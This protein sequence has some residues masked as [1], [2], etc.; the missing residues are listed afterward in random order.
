MSADTVNSFKDYAYAAHDQAEFLHRAMDELKSMNES[1]FVVKKNKELM[2]E[3]KELIEQL[4][5]AKSS[6]F[7][8]QT[9][10]FNANA[11]NGSLEEIRHQLEIERNRSQKA[12][13][14]NQRVENDKERLNQQ[15]NQ[16]LESY[17]QL[18]TSHNELMN[19]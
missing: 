9:A 14:K 16:M 3:K 6:G 2:R 18:E 8:E 17:R 11:G 7:Q 15:L 13:Q 5:L 19:G 12:W 10:S 1:H 4:S